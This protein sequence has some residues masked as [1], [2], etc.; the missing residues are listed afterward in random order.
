MALALGDSRIPVIY[1][2]KFREYGL[3][4]DADPVMQIISH[5]PWCGAKLP[6]SLRNEF[7]DELD[8]MGLEPES[9]DLPLQF[10]SDAWWR[11]RSP[12]EP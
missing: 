8:R 11:L 4:A 5:C 7:F 3:G 6:S 9:P 10:R 1:L 2:P 12:G